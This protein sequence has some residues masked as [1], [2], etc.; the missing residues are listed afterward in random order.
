MTSSEPT[1]T[2]VTEP[3]ASEAS[4]DSGQRYCWK[5]SKRTGLLIIPSMPTW[6]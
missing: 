1:R 3:L 5:F 4:M 6:R 2:G